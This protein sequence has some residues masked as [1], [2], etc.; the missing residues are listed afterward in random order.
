MNNFDA[1]KCLFSVLK[2]QRKSIKPPNRIKVH[3]IIETQSQG[4]NF[5]DIL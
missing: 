3:P 2:S 4:Y 5:S 1:Y